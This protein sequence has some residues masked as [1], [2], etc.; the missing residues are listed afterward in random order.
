MNSIRSLALLAVAL[1]AVSGP[2]PASGDLLDNPPR[3][4]L[5]ETILVSVDY[6]HDLELGLDWLRPGDTLDTAL[7]DTVRNWVNG[8]QAS[9]TDAIGQI[10]ADA[11]LASSAI[12]Q[13]SLGLLNDSILLQDLM[14]DALDQNAKVKVLSKPNILAMNTQVAAIEVLKNHLIVPGIFD[15]GLS[16]KESKAVG[17]F[18]QSAHVFQDAL[19]LY[20]I[21][22]NPLVGLFDGAE[23]GN[24]K[25]ILARLQ[26]QE[27]ENL[28]VQLKKGDLVM[29]GTEKE[30]TNA[31]VV[32]ST[33]LPPEFTIILPTLLPEKLSNKKLDALSNFSFGVEVASDR[34]SPPAEYAGFEV[35]LTPQGIAQAF[36]FANG[37]VVDVF[38]VDAPHVST[39]TATTTV[40]VK[41]GSTLT[42]GGI[43]EYENGEQEMQT[44][45]IPGLGDLPVFRTFFRN[46]SK[47]NSVRNRELLILVTPE[48]ISL[49]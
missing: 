48:I 13:S 24:K 34:G 28:K 38:P 19:Q 39:R 6:H 41:D 30:P 32:L 4:V 35:Q 31:S 11:A 46:M 26:L 2:R 18:Y 9:T 43:F 42:I 15:D 40:L 12:G 27:L 49:P 36:T 47:N 17:Q 21:T 3:Q 37:A 33:K 14:L 7:A 10:Q 16:K 25:D 22:T 5:I 45:Q 20:G 23:G 44:S 1:L 8:A 29:R